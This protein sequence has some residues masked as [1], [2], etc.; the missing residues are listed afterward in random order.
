MY[1]SASRLGEDPFRI[2][3]A[4]VR[5]ENRFVLRDHDPLLALLRQHVHAVERTASQAPSDVRSDATGWFDFSLR[6]SRRQRV[7]LL[8]IDIPGRTRAELL[9]PRVV[10]VHR[11]IVAG[12]L[13]V[14]IVGQHALL[15]KDVV[16][17]VVPPDVPTMIVDILLLIRDRLFLVLGI[18]S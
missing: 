15:I 7:K 11:S 10:H 13:L 16:A 8:L 5:T 6:S 4:R 14:L 3:P 2:L 9:I 18:S 17:V 12:S 1:E